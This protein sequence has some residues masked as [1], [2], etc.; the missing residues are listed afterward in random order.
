M[1]LTPT[2]HCWQSFDDFF[3]MG[4]VARP[5]LASDAW[6]LIVPFE[7]FSQGSSTQITGRHVL[8]RQPM[9]NFIIE[10]HMSTKCFPV[11]LLTG[12][13]EP[14]SAA[15]HHH[16]EEEVR[17]SRMCYIQIVLLVVWFWILVTNKEDWI[18]FGHV[19]F[20]FFL[21]GHVR[22][23]FFCFKIDHA[24]SAIASI[25]LIDI[26]FLT[27]RVVDWA[28]LQV[29]IAQHIHM[30]T[31]TYNNNNIN[32]VFSCC[33]CQHPLQ[34]LREWRTDAQR[35]QLERQKNLIRNKSQAKR[36]YH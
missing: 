35:K 17:A 36:H 33:F 1:G 3:G 23:V 34:F 5:P 10:L 31:I 12:R 28:A 30:S 18:V 25:F 15:Q 9:C 11:L 20:C 22:P 24:R 14:H 21:S 7:S 27:I 13:D 29:Q 32:I 8:M 19:W 6:S 2:L 16:C 4:A 26:P